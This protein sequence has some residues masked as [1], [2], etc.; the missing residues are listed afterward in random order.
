MAIHIGLTIHS[1]IS[2]SAGFRFLER[3]ERFKLIHEL[4]KYNKRG[5][6]YENDSK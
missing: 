3:I 5:E 2:R 4:R 1:A 6:R